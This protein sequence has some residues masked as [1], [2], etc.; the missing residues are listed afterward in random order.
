MFMFMV[1]DLV[2]YECVY[3]TRQRVVAGVWFRLESH[4][5][6]CVSCHVFTPSPEVLLLPHLTMESPQWRRTPGASR[7]D[8]GE[9]LAGKRQWSGPLMQWTHI[10]HHIM[11]L[12][13]SRAALSL[14]FIVSS[15]P[16][17]DASLKRNSSMNSLFVDPSHRVLLRNFSFHTMHHVWH[18]DVLCDASGFIYVQH[19]L[20]NPVQMV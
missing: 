13:A 15:P 14:T 8:N 11:T 10:F 5:A 9:K 4:E 16:R 7:Q 1:T 12:C 2:S 6:W 18:D 20:T 19:V 17:G 3:T